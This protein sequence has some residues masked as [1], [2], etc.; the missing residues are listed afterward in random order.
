MTSYTKIKDQVKQN[1]TLKEIIEFYIGKDIGQN[2]RYKCP[3]N[4]NEQHHNLE[5]KGKR[6]YCY[7]CGEG[8]DE[9]AFVMKLFDSSSYKEALEILANDFKLSKNTIEDKKFFDELKKKREKREKEKQFKQLLENKE[10]ELFIKLINKNKYIVSR[11]EKIL[12]Y[13]KYN[14]GGYRFSS[15]AG[16]YIKLDKEQ[17]IIDNLINI[18][19]LNDVDISYIYKYN[20]D[21]DEKDYRNKL[22]NCV[23]LD[24]INN[25]INI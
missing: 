2:K 18:L 15:L 20:I 23:V 6:W 11:M 22:K 21:M 14:L 5:I 7:S 13:N 19:S 24:Y 3:F 9:V 8:G 17:H 16:E 1:L 25:Q 10:N 12:P 4:P